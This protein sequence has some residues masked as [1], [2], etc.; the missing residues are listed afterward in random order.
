[1]SESSMENFTEDYPTFSD[2]FFLVI[3]VHFQVLVC[4]FM[5]SFHDRLKAIKGK[6]VAEGLERLEYPEGFYLI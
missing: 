1:M 5:H 6:N 3:T 2:S 4:I